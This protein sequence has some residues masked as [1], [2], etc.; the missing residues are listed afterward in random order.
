MFYRFTICLLLALG[1]VSHATA[2]TVR[3]MRITTADNV[4]IMGSYYAVPE[5]NAPAVVLLHGY[6]QHRATW[7][8][9]A[10]A[11]Q[12][13][14]IAS[15]AVDLRGHGDSNRRLTQY[16]PQ[17]IDLAK[18][19]PQ[20]YQDMLMDIESAVGWLEKQ[21]GIN[22]NRIAMVGASISA[23]LAIRYAAINT[24]LAALVLLSPGLNNASELR[25]DDVFAQL[26]HIPLRLAVSR[27][28]DFYY[29]SARRLMVIRAETG[30]SKPEELLVFTGNRHGTD[31]LIAVKTLPGLLL[32]FLESSLRKQVSEP[33][34]RLTPPPPPAP[35][36]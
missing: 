17:L 22:A 15:L 1:W 6:R 30:H 28:D 2:Q 14:G 26:G 16:G 10:R 9:F 12:K 7:L 21:P 20:D 32:D 13:R 8:D 36:P 4:V 23:N 31:L 19:R 33:E 27:N 29:N 35:M 18:F 3:T 5:D 25:T 24:D 34:M 11:L